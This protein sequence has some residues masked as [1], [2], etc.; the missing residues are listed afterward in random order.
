MLELKFHL[1]DGRQIFLEAFLQIKT[2]AGLLEGKPNETVNRSVLESHAA[3]AKALWPQE[4][5]V[6]LG[7]DYYTS[8]IKELLPAITCAGQFISYEPAIDSGKSGSSLEAIS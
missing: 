8:R 3:A 5:R 7:L 2:Y 6:S 1:R 4:P